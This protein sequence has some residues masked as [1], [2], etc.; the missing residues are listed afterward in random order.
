M[1]NLAADMMKAF[2]GVQ[3][4]P[5]SAKFFSTGYPPLDKII[6]GSYQGGIPQGQIVE[7][8]G[9]S[10][11]G[12]THLATEIM[13]S[14]Q[15]QGGCAMFVDWERRFKPDFAARRGLNIDPPHFVHVSPP[16]WE[17]GNSMGLRF[18]E[19][20]RK[21]GDYDP[22][23]PIVV[24]LDSIA[25]AIPESMMIDKSKSGD[26]ALDRGKSLSFNMNDT[27]ALARV[28]STTLK[29]IAHYAREF[30]ATFTYI[31]QIRVKP[32]VSFGDPTCTPG[33]MATEFYADCRLSLSRAMDKDGNELAGQIVTAKT[34]KNAITRP[35]QKVSW[36]LSFL[37]DGD[38]VFDRE[39]SLIEYLVDSGK[40]E[41]P[42]KGYYTW[43]AGS[44]NK[45]RKKA[46]VEAIRQ[47]QTGYQQL[48]D[49]LS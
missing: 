38:T 25:A 7:I 47:S 49:L 4:K 26:A 39:A 22:E 11:S 24:V 37:D 48:L 5:Q 17:E 3:T 33:G 8:F 9:P 23:T 36:V 42:T 31:N 32:G 19:M 20:I 30:N 18:A 15:A 2:G 27:T 35:M 16:T 13:K 40:I 14:A 34:V 28:T 46:L 29:M 1:S 45:V 12:K 6:S 10:Q 44:G 21:S 41:S 43:P